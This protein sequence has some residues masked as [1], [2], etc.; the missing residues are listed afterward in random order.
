MELLALSLLAI[1]VWIRLFDWQ[2]YLIVLVTMTGAVLLEDIRTRAYR[3]DHI[4]R[5]ILPG[6][7][8]LVLYRPILAWAPFLGSRRFLRADRSRRKCARNTRFTDR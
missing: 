6:P 1:G 8:E 3:I 7:V 4:A 2:I 5:L